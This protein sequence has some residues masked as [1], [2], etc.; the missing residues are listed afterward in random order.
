MLDARLS[1]YHSAVTFANAFMNAGTTSDDF[2]R[3]NLEWLSRA[4]NWSKFSATAALGVIH[5]GQLSRGLS[6]LAPYLPQDGVTA[7][8]YSE[9]GSLFALGLIHANH[10]DEV[11]DYLRGVLKETQIE[12]LQHGACLGLGTAGMAT[13]NDGT[14]SL[15]NCAHEATFVLALS[16]FLG[17][18]I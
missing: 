8:P 17:T 1:V 18:H 12:V 10:G 4:T 14:F 16:Y 6:L 13:D 7:S 3:Q 2:L 11:L 5:K 9:G 15:T